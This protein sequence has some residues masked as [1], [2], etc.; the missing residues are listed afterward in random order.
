MYISRWVDLFLKHSNNINQ[1]YIQE[2]LVGILQNNPESI[3]ATINKQK[4]NELIQSFFKEAEVVS[5]DTF[6]TTKYLR[7]FSTFIV[8][9]D[10]VIR[11][12]QNIILNQFFKN[13]DNQQIFRVKLQFK[14][15]YQEDP[16]DIMSKIKSREVLIAFG[17]QQFTT[18]SKFFRDWK[19]KWNYFIA[20]INLLA[21]ICI[22][23]NNEAIKNVSA[24]LS[25]QMIATILFDPDI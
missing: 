9:Q 17:K 5:A 4:I 24:L 2:C 13:S 18:I 21:D 20:Y 14:A 16:T 19:S 12:N 23:R 11:E 1:P 22:D 7:L 25:L 10:R 8:C 6:L 3:E 15:D